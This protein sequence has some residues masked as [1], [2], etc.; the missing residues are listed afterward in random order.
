MSLRN[1]DDIVGKANC[2]CV[3]NAEDGIACRHDLELAG[4]LP[5]RDD[6]DPY[7]RAF[8]AITDPDDDGS[9]P[10]DDDAMSNPEFD[11]PDGE[12]DDDLDDEFGE[13]EE[14]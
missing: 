2:R 5:R 12:D 8:R 13:E 1:R 9:D 4:E 7:D 14:F 11:E 6:K 10:E 3:Y